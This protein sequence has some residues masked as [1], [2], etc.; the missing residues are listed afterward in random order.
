MPD[1]TEV[2]DAWGCETQVPESEAQY[3]AE[4][5][6]CRPCCDEWLEPLEELAGEEENS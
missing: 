6:L 4:F 5:R 1:L 2:C 3:L